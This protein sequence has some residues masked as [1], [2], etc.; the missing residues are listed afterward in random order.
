[1]AFHSAL[2]EEFVKGFLPGGRMH[3]G[4]LGQHAI[5]V[6][7][8]G[9][10]PLWRDSIRRLTHK[11]VLPYFRVS[12]HDASITMQVLDPDQ[13]IMTQLQ[14]QEAVEPWHQVQSG[15]ETYTRCCGWRNGSDDG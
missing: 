13:S 10:E 4:G 12:L 9:I 8:Y 14:T 1:M 11:L 6:E 7:Q 2:L 3:L 15:E 5:Q